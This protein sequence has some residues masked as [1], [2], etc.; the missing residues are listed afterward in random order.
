GF[1][2]VVEI[3]VPFFIWA[4]RRLRLIAGGLMIFLQVVI[5]LTGN[6]CFFNLL[7]IA[8]CLLL[9]DDRS[10]CRGSGSL[11]LGTLTASPTGVRSTR[12]ALSDRLSSYAAVAVIIVTLPI[13]AWLIFSAFKPWARPPP[14]LAQLSEP[15]G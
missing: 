11:P 12:R 13:N 3:I 4:P 5:G 14:A 8:L 9:I 7:T 15:L 1:C 2:L 10:L 6:Y